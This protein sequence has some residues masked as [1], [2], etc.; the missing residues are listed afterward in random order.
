METDDYPDTR[1][2][3]KRDGFD[4]AENSDIE[5]KVEKTDSDSELTDLDD[6]DNL[7]ETEDE[8]TNGLSGNSHY[9]ESSE[10]LPK[11]AV[12]DPEF[13]EIRRDLNVPPAQVIEIIDR[14]GCNSQRVLNLRS[15]AEELVRMPSTRREKVAI[16][17]NTGA[18]TL[19]Y[20]GCNDHADFPQAR[21]LYS[22]LSSASTWLRP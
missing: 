11:R 10:P 12:Y 17:G 5:P 22:T 8:E 21:V 13:H 18:G 3:R 2:K 14:S 4:E 15:N 6:L 20:D 7:G 9:E 19:Q 1:A 16:V